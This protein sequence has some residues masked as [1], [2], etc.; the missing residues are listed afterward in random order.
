VTAGSALRRLRHALA[1]ALVAV[2]AI[3]WFAAVN[4]DALLSE[5]LSRDSRAFG[6][7]SAVWSMSADRALERPLLGHGLGS[8]RLLNVVY[9]DEFGDF[10]QM[11]AHSTWLHAAC[12][13]GALGA[14]TLALFMVLGLAGV[15]R[16]CRSTSGPERAISVGSLGGLV[17]LL[18][19]GLFSVTTDAEP[20]MLFF[21]LMALGGSGVSRGGGGSTGSSVDER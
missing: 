17:V 16:A 1:F 7:R 6:I 13:T 4:P 18:V 11:N 19:A 21:S 15:V 20:G 9:S 14:G 3:L 12:E 8:Y 5:A 2:G 10:H